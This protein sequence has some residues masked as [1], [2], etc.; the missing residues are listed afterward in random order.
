MPQTPCT[1]LAPTGSST[2]HLSKIGIV[3]QVK[4]AP[5][6]PIKM[7]SHARYKKQPAVIETN[8]PNMPLMRSMISTRPS[9][10]YI[11]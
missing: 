3:I 4:N 9:F 11:E 7:A 2:D 8:E 6:A 1:E 5:I 10:R